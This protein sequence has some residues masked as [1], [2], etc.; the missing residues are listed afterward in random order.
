VKA[1][2]RNS[3]TLK[4]LLSVV[5]SLK[6]FPLG[7]M[8]QRETS[9]KKDF[10]WQHLQKQQADVG[11]LSVQS[12]DTFPAILANWLLKNLYQL[13]VE[14]H[15]TSS[16]LHKLSMS[17]QSEITSVNSQ[18]NNSTVTVNSVSKVAQSCLP[19]ILNFEAH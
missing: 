7:K 5:T 1:P 18:K 9:V 4:L 10:L 11:L 6:K 19:E 16:L 3:A 8:M 15:T 13:W 14:I 17:M 2:I 12:K